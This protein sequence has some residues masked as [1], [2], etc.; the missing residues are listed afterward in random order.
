MQFIYKL[1]SNGCILLSVMKIRETKLIAAFLFT[2]VF[3]VSIPATGQNTNNIED[4]KKNPQ[5][6]IEIQK[7]GFY[8]AAR[9]AIVHHLKIKNNSSLT[10]KR[11]KI[12]VDY[13]STSPTN[14]GNTVSFEE[15]VLPI[16]LPP[17]STNT[18]L[19][20]GYPIGAGSTS[21]L[22]K[23]IEVLSADAFVN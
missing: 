19:K 16:E 7:W 18:Y 3:L 14:Y 1:F 22:G 11:V 23:S 9:V 12:R 8:V 13:G 21:L 20:G 2:A 15:A 5:N 4:M 6:Y 17:D 10:Y